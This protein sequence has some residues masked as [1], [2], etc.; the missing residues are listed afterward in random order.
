MQKRSTNQ[1]ANASGA[2][3]VI[4]VTPPDLSR[5]NPARIQSIKAWHI[6]QATGPD[7]HVAALHVSITECGHVK[8]SG[9]SIEPAHACII[10]AELDSI[11]QHLS[12]Y[13]ADN[14]R[15]TA[16]VTKIRP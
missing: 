16:S 3:N 2:S 7:Q 8:A 11:K 1:A 6:A 13:L 4:T 10:L 9:L 15:P 5:A 12:T 14:Q